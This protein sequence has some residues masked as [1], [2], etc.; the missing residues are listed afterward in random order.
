ME[1][2]PVTDTIHFGLLTTIQ[3]MV[4]QDLITGKMF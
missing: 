3:E 4:N 1:L 2:I